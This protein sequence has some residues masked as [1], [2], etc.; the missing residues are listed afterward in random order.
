MLAGNS[1]NRR[2]FLNL[3]RF[4]GNELRHPVGWGRHARRL[5]SHPLR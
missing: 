3:L 4:L 5:P 2:E 1:V